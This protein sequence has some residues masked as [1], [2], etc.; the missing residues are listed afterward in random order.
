MENRI[1]IAVDAMGGDNAPGEIINGAI[2]AL[3][4]SEANIMLV[5][6][7][8][9]IL[10]ELKKYSY[11]ES[12]ITVINA[13]EVIETGEI[14][15]TAIR[16]KKDS[17]LVVGLKLVKDKKAHGFVSA[18]STGAVL[19]GA[20]IIIGRI[21]GLERPVSMM[22]LPNKKSKTL[23]LDA[24]ANV[25]CKP[26]YLVQ[27]AKIGNIYA[28]NI[29]NIDKPKIGLLNIGVEELKGNMLT[30]ETYQLLKQE[31]SLNFVGNIESREIPD[32]VVDVLV[33]DGFS[34]NLILKYAEGLSQGIINII[35]NEIK[36]LEIPKEIGIL[37]KDTIG[38]F[39]K[40]YDYTE[41]GGAP[42]LGLKGLVIKAHGS[43][44]SKAI[45]NAIIQCVRC[46]EQD[47]ISKME[48]KI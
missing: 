47:I 12:R 39:N 31:T 27:F 24:G 46:S 15:T 2:Q 14:P 22:S 17:S 37:L 13:T 19:T 26:S 6:K 40:K 30:K 18:G 1:I 5:G 10:Q 8:D 9:V 34:G 33:C 4:V 32:G 43:S 36:S 35:K 28:Q 20:T 45:K 29:L 23:L 16:E 41:I 21:L 48:A 7:E 11:D 44:N 38:A 3:D 25:D 42:F